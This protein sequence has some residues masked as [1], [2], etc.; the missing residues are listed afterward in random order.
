MS[1][2]KVWAGVDRCI[3]D[4]LR[5]IQRPLAL[6]TAQAYRIVSHRMA[7]VARSH[8]EMYRRV[9]Q[10]SGESTILT[11]GTKHQL[12]CQARRILLVKWRHHLAVEQAHVGRRIIEAI[13]LLLSE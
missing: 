8:A 6:R 3:K 13:A 1:L 11:A 4:A 10:L 7:T 12:R 2:P 5:R 9:R